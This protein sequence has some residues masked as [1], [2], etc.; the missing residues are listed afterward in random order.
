MPTLIPIQTVYKN[1]RFRSR[2]EARWAVALDAM[3]ITWLYEDQ[4]FDLD[5][6]RYLPDFWLPQV[7]M[8]A[9]V[10][11]HWPDGT[12]LEKIYRLSEA[13]GFPLLI[14]DGLPEMTSYWTL[15]RFDPGDGGA[16]IDEW[17][18]VVLGEGHAYHK[19]EG[20]FYSHTGA[21]FPSREPLT[22]IGCPSLGKAVRM[23]W[24]ARFEHGESG[25][26]DA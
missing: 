17:V 22:D 3:E 21:H 24:G 7:R 8:F 14:L 18:D 10:K 26:H 15:R 2:T 9:E 1:Y 4:G 5:G 23:S 13:S 12:E 16:K 19:T 20:R 6:L 11:P 25:G